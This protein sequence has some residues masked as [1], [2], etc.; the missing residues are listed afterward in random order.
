MPKKSKRAGELP[1][2]YVNPPPSG[3]KTTMVEE[4]EQ[5]L[6]EAGMG[7]YRDA[8]MEDERRVN[9]AARRGGKR[10]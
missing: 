9:K 3:K 5:R 8:M 7:E 4:Y 1:E 6:R 2:Q 10:K